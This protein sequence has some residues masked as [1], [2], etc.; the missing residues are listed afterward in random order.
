MGGEVARRR[1]EVGG[2]D[3][4]G[5]AGIAVA[6]I[7]AVVVD[8]APQLMGAARFCAGGAITWGGGGVT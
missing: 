2:G 5:V 6:E 4:L 8:V 3:S 7:A 1:G